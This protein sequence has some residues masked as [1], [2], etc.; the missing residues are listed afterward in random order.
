MIKI[1]LFI[2]ITIVS[3]DIESIY[4][5]GIPL[6]IEKFNLTIIGQDFQQNL[7]TCYF[8]NENKKIETRI[9]YLNETIIICP[10]PKV[11]NEMKMNVSVLNEKKEIIIY[12]IPI[13]DGLLPDSG[14]IDGNTWIRI[15]FKTD[16]LFPFYCK[17]G[18]Q[19]SRGRK[20]QNIYECL[21]PKYSLPQR[22]LFE[23]SLNRI[24]FHPTYLLFLYYLNPEFNRIIPEFGSPFDE[25][26]MKILGQ[27]FFENDGSKCKFGQYQSKSIFISS[28]EIQCIT[29][30]TNLNIT[31]PIQFTLNGYQYFNTG[32]NFTFDSL[33]H[34]NQRGFCTNERKC[35][36]NKGWSGNQCE[37]CSNQCNHGL[38]NENGDCICSKGFTG[39]NC[40]IQEFY[41]NILIIIFGFLFLFFILFTCLCILRNFQ[42]KNLFNKSYSSL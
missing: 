5:F 14:S 15:L 41:W 20:R 42:K 36:C 40:N 3:S 1:I 26:N 6:G 18:D 23:F 9:L 11:L 19:I 12:S 4:P 33:C 13:V 22:V 16:F 28:E 7:T 37:K 10:I 32:Y 17:F 21:I 34:C 29:P 30:I 27:N 2:L 24:H 31:I 38:C 35:Q 39:S 8:E 25:T